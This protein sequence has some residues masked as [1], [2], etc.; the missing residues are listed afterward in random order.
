MIKAISLLENFG[1]KI[2]G[3]VSDEI[4]TNRK[5]WV[6]FGIN[7]T[8][9][10]VKN[11]FIHPLDDTRKIYMFSDATNLIKNVRNRLVNKK[12]L[13]VPIYFFKE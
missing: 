4:S 9:D 2:D 12:S 5:L 1:A 11:S 8:M 6:K 3:I 10:D 13:R 7:G